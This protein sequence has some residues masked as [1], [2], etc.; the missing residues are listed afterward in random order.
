MN[1]RLEGTGVRRL[2]VP[3]MKGRQL[4]GKARNEDEDSR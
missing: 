1:I 2:A 4:K 3:E